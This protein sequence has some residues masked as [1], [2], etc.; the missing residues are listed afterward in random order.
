MKLFVI[1]D[2]LDFCGQEWWKGDFK[3][4]GSNEW[5]QFEGMIKILLCILLMSWCHFVIST[6][7]IFMNFFSGLM[8]V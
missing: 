8:V 5:S 2:G 1:L 6:V 3:G 4:C 7:N